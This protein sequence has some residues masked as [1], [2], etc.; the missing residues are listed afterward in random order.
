LINRSG[1]ITQQVVL[2]N[3]DITNIRK[4]HE[5]ICKKR[6]GGRGGEVELLNCEIGLSKF[7]AT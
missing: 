6:G 7:S 1:F 2:G 4:L 5:K 3:R